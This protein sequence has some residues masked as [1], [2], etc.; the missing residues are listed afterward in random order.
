M[1]ARRRTAHE[2]KIELPTPYVDSNKIEYEGE[3]LADMDTS[4]TGV[5]ELFE[6]KERVSKI[7]LAKG[8][9]HRVKVT[10][11]QATFNRLDSEFH[12]SV[13]HNHLSYRKDIELNI[14]KD[15]IDR[16]ILMQ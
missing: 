3:V 9:H 14:I 8:Q 4:K 6:E 15:T 12:S 1:S 7:R 16:F 10:L 13:G 5:E 2:S 11:D